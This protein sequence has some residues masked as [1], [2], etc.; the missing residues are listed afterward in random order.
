MVIRGEN[1]ATSQFGELLASNLASC[2]HIKHKGSGKM[3]RVLNPEE[4]EPR[5]AG[6]LWFVNEH[7]LKLHE[8]E[9]TMCANFSNRES[10]REKI[11]YI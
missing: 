7:N 1:R 8:K 2:A 5:S 3:S 9:C 10:I 6:G 11:G 4:W